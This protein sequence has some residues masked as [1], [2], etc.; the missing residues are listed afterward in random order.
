MSFLNA[1]SS[2]FLSMASANARPPDSAA[3]AA[4]LPQGRLGFRAHDFDREQ[5]W[6]NMSRLLVAW[7]QVIRHTQCMYEYP[8]SSAPR[9]CGLQ[10]VSSPAAATA[11]G[12]HPQVADIEQVSDEG[13]KTLS[14]GS[15]QT[16]DALLPVQAPVSSV[17]C[18]ARHT[19][20]NRNLRRLQQQQLQ[21]LNAAS[22]DALRNALTIRVE[23]SNTSQTACAAR[24]AA[25]QLVDSP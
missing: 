6:G 25:G 1:T 4:N 18:Y 8:Q 10:P 22:R 2:I 5:R 20:F 13:V 23:M 19:S 21:A 16:C 12:G 24:A 3:L 11:A 17:T 7:V 14:T 9:I 15:I